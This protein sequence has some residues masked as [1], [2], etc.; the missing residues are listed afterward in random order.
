MGMAE[1]VPE[2]T[3]L[4]LKE[5]MLWRLTQ[6]ALETT[7][8]VIAH[9]QDERAAIAIVLFVALLFGLVFREVRFLAIVAVLVA[10]VTRVI[11]VERR[12]TKGKKAR[13]RVRAEIAVD[14]KK[15]KA[16]LPSEFRF[17]YE[18]NT[19]LMPRVWRLTIADEKH[20]V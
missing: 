14:L 1:R 12:N 13:D 16:I 7:D 5:I 3:A 18:V 10:V 6:E 2:K 9:E 19:D 11:I 15:A 4:L 8:S 17:I 20:P